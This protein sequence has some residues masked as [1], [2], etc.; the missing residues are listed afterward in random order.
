M[1]VVIEKKILDYHD[2]SHFKISKHENYWMS[3]PDR[4]RKFGGGVQKTLPACAANMGSKISHLVYEWYKMQNLV[5][6]RVDFHNFPKKIWEKYGDFVQNL[7]QNWAV[8]YMN[9]SLFL[10]KKMLFV[11]VYFQIPQRHVPTKIKFE[12]PPVNFK[13]IPVYIIIDW[14][15][16]EI[17]AGLIF[18]LFFYQ[19][20]LHY[21][22]DSQN[23]I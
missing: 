22:H 10:W 8:W 2:Y 19:N 3:T 20:Y 17:W 16:L 6:E 15:S 21:S 1:V 7:V 13:V 12:H 23:H 11:W 5:Y 14:T 18:L 9:G 4:S